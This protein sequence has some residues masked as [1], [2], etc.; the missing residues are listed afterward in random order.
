MTVLPHAVFLATDSDGNEFTV[1]LYRSWA[2]AAPSHG[3][4]RTSDGRQ[5]SRIG[6]GAYEIADRPRIPIT[7]DDPEAP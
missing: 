5:V 3:Q 7:S 2:D 4:L 1:Y 6:R